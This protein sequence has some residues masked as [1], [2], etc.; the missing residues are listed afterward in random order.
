MRHD[1]LH[2]EP[3]SILRPLGL[4]GDRWTM[5]VLRQA[6]AGVRRFEDFHSVLGLSRAVLAERLARLVD[7]GIFERRAYRDARRTRH[8]YRLTDKGMD[9]Y[10]VLM[11]LRTWGDKYLAPDGPFAHYR[12]VECGGSAE[13]HLVCDRCGD[14]LTARDVQL[15]AGAGLRAWA[16][17][18]AAGSGPG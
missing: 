4:L 16:L 15:E 10:P 2:L 14:E 13:I 5:V 17:G 8:E 18:D 7:A 6:F 9:L 11:A 12:H 1:D 3:C